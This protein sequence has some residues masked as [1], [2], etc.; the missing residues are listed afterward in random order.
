MGLRDNMNKNPTLGYAVV[1]GVIALAA[2]IAI[3]NLSGADPTDDKNVEYYY[4]YDLTTKQLFSHDALDPDGTPPIAA[5]SGSQVD[6]QDAGVKAYVFTCAAECGDESQYFIA[7]LEKYTSEYKAALKAKTA[8]TQMSESGV[9]ISLEA[10]DK[11]IPK[12]KEEGQK[13]M[14]EVPNSKCAGKYR[15]CWPSKKF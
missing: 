4:Y 9:L 6:G 15:E 11:W 10:T 1:G 3:V 13:L 14:W 5:P 7:Y 8:D 2:L 12:Y